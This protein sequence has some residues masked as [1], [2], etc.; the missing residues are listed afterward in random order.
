MLMGIRW[1]LF[2][3]LFLP[4][5]Q[6]AIDEEVFAL[7]QF[8]KAIFEDPSSRLSD[9]DPDEDDPCSWTGII[10]SGNGDHVIS[11]NVSNSSLEG[12]LAP[13]LGSLLFLEELI[14]RGNSFRG[15]IPR[16]IGKLKRLTALDLSRNRFSGPIPQEIKNLDKITKI[17]L[18]ANA[19]TGKIPVE[20]WNFSNLVEL[21]LDKNK[22][23][24]SI[25]SVL[26]E[27]S[28]LCLS[29]QL[30]FLNISYNFL[31]GKVPS[32]LSYLPRDGFQGNCMQEESV[33]QRS[34]QQC[35]KHQEET[36]SGSKLTEGRPI[37]EKL[38]RGK[39]GQPVWLLI[40]E[41]FT[42]VV[43]AAF[44]IMSIYTAIRK[45]KAKSLLIAR[46]KKTI[47]SRDSMLMS[48]DGALIKH[49]P[50]FS[51]QQLEIACEDFSN[52]IGSSPDIILY[53][54][55]MKDGPEIAVI[56]LIASINDWEPC[57]ELLFQKKVADLARTNH[58][59]VSK[60]IGY[61]REDCPF[62]RMLVF[63]YASNGTLYEHLHYGEGSQLYWTKRMRIAIGIA[64][65]L[66]HLHNELQPPFIIS[67]LNSGS[68]YLTEDFSP[69]LADIESWRSMIP[70][71][72]KIGAAFQRFPDSSETK[73]A[74]VRENT[75]AFGVM[76][77]EIVSGRPPYCKDRGKLVNWAVEYLKKP[78]MMCHLVD[79][80]LRYFKHDDL[81]VI[82]NAVNL[83]IQS[84]PAKIPSMREICAML[85]DGIDTSAAADLKES[86][87]AWAELVLSS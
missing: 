70:K 45:F 16:E 9:W 11:L 32:C 77:L 33:L 86:P 69:K 63:E 67:D 7:K 20:I 26:H 43:V 65:G 29:R 38:D 78:D 18:R 72:G 60:V 68:V 17:N 48:L 47:K 13:E 37:E 55:I 46:W 24:G 84:E 3:L 64:R 8:K 40:L 42:G 36:Y 19:L 6:S 14:L 44:M 27:G 74:D 25:S 52:I 28:R 59:N 41:I 4:C 1:L 30:E 58:E 50:A 49:A 76:L 73:H 10:C 66:R 2:G 57:H 5:C 80:E 61:C 75:I 83:C 39:S 79:P 35:A 15:V 34:A 21:R 71:S 62:T 51:R 22:L 54:G 56:S 85:E 53:K 81:R 87:L 23:D 82:C 12:F 31:V